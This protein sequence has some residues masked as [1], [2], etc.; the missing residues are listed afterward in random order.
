M[1]SSAYNNNSS[2]GFSLEKVQRF[3]SPRKELPATID[4]Q[5]TTSEDPEKKTSAPKEDGFYKAQA[6]EATSNAADAEAAQKALA[7]LANLPT[8]VSQLMAGTNGNGMATTAPQIYVIN[9]GGTPTPPP[10]IDMEVDTTPTQANGGGLLGLNPTTTVSLHEGAGG[11]HHAE[12]H[13]GGGGK[14][15]WFNSVFPF[16]VGGGEGFDWWAQFSGGAAVGAVLAFMINGVARLFEPDYIRPIINGLKT[17]V[18]GV[19]QVPFIGPF[20]GSILNIGVDLFTP[21]GEFKEIFDETTQRRYRLVLKPSDGSPSYVEASKNKGLL[22]KMGING[23]FVDFAQVYIGAEPGTVKHKFREF[24]RKVERLMPWAPETPAE[25]TLPENSK[26]HKI[27]FYDV[28]N[29][30]KQIFAKFIGDASQPNQVTLKEMLSSTQLV[31]D[32]LFDFN[33]VKQLYELKKVK[34]IDTAGKTIEIAFNWSDS[35]NRYVYTLPA[36]KI[37]AEDKKLL[38]E[39]IAS[40]GF[41]KLDELTPL[42]KEVLGGVDIKR[43]TNAAKN[44]FGEILKYIPARGMALGA[45]LGSVLAM[46]YGYYEMGHKHLSIESHGG[47]GEGK[48]KHKGKDTSIDSA[49]ELEAIKRRR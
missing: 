4:D 5:A 33:A 23:G 11:G 29:P 43:H 38:L 24:G 42:A 27:T 3:S 2:M 17:V 46:Y 37:I 34:T 8:P 14:F 12:G 45:L 21:R 7:P 49:T 36:G 26:V 10:T 39:S 6:T 16:P 19:N 9:A 1:I 25:F 28:E 40:S 35:L 30:R 48:G 44:T 15:N 20:C 13:H 18:N 22:P 32:K 41:K 31:V 47:E